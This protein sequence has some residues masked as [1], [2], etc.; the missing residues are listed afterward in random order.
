MN[1]PTTERSLRGY[2]SDLVN[3]GREEVKKGFTAIMFQLATGGGK[4]RGF[5]NI[6]NRATSIKSFNGIKPN[7]WII[8]P[9]KK[10]VRQASKELRA[11][12]VIHGLI[13]ANSKEQRCFDVHVCSR[14]TLSRRIKKSL[15]V[16]PPTIVIIDEAHTGLDFQIMLKKWLHKNTLFLGWTATPERLDGRGLTEIYEV[17]VEG[18]PLQWLVEHGYLKHPKCYEFEPIA[19]INDLKFNKNGDVSKKKAEEIFIGGKYRYGREIEN[20]REN[21]LGRAFLVFCSSIVLSKQTAESFR[22]KGLRVEHV[23]GEM[24][25]KEIESV[26]SRLERG[27]LDGITSVELIIYG[28]DVPKLSCIIMLR[29]TDSR[30]LYFQMIGRGLRPQEE[31]AD[32]LIFDHVGNID[33]LGHPLLPVEWNFT[34]NIKKMK[35]PKDAIIKIEAVKRCKI[36]FDHIVN[37]VCRGD[38]THAQP[39]FKLPMKQVDGYLVEIKEPTPLRERPIENQRHYEDMINNNTD[40]FRAKWLQEGIIDINSVTNLI[41]CGHELKRSVMWVYYQL[42]EGDKMVNVS[43]LS[44]IQLIKIPDVKIRYKDGW[45]YRKREELE[46]QIRIVA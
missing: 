18:P 10:L 11:E 24:H 42:T 34:G 5:A 9:R 15:I 37:G 40:V 3:A 36:C 17:M 44:A 32:C 35:V 16:N 31:Y 2:Q 33:R 29:K 4:T 46:R 12:G 27:E 45:V 30:A 21:A 26:L 6:T 1:A 39:D 28:L 23:D 20:Y 38:S 22:E 19:G 7:I 41:Q 13:N 43:L 14:E 25:D 8:A